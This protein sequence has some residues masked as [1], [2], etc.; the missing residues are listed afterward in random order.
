MHERLAHSIEVLI[1]QAVKGTWLATLCFLF[2]LVGAGLLLGFGPKLALQV[3][4]PAILVTPPLWWS[5]V[6][7]MPL[8]SPGR[9]AIAGALIVPMVWIVTLATFHVAT[10]AMR[11]PDWH[12]N[13]AVTSFVTMAELWFGY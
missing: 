7:R 1:A 6:R 12:P 13:K 2:G 3:A 5:L 10:R 11:P 9:G 8:A 4:A